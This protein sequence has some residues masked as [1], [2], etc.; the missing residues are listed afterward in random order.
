M[1]W[2]F[3]YPILQKN[4]LCATAMNHTFYCFNFEFIRNAYLMG[5]EKYSPTIGNISAS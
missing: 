2:F 5:I 1:Y 4:C 3:F